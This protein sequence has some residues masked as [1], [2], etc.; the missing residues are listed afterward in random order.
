MYVCG[1]KK[2][3]AKINDLISESSFPAFSIIIGGTGT[4]KKVISEYISRKLNAEF[5]PC[6]ISVDSVRNAIQ[7]SYIGNTGITR[8]FVFYDCDNMSV[9]AKNALLKV[10]EEPPKNTYFIM[11]ACDVSSMLPTVISRGTVFTIDQYTISDVYDFIEHYGSL[12]KITYTPED[13]DIMESVCTCPYDVILASKQNL[14]EVYDLADKFIQFI[15][16]SSLANELKVTSMLNLKK[17][18]NGI[19]PVLFLRCVLLCCSKFIVSDIIKEDAIIF[20]KIIRRTSKAIYEIMKK[21]S[22]KQ[23]V[24]DNYIMNL[25]IDIAGGV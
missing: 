18:E 17:D 4:G 16:A 11:T 20:D 9:S 10:T 21:G 6:D 2:L 13:I 24:L 23:I 7:E 19:D 15:G 25:H 8:L 5:I 12:K 3:I 1:Q 14:K 22:N